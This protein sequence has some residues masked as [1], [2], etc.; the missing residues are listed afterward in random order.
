MFALSHVF[1]DLTYI[2]ICVCYHLNTNM[3]SSKESS[4]SPCLCNNRFLVDY[5]V[6]V[7]VICQVKAV[8]DVY[9][10]IFVS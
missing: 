8:I 10:A 6:Y 9:S 4:H 1:L 5:S 2:W 7:M 3:I